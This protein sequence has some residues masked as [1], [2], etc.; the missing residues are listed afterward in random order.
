MADWG[1]GYVTE[2]GYSFGYYDE[3]LPSRLALACLGKGIAAPGLGEEPLRVLE[4]GSGQG[5]TANI[6]AAVNPEIDYTAVDFNPTH[7]SAASS[8]AHEAGTPN[9][10]FL[11]ASFSDIAA[12]DSLGQFDVITLHG[13]YTWVSAENREHIIRIA[14]DKL[15]TGGLLYISYNCFPGWTTVAPIRRLFTDV[16]AAAP[17][18]PIFDRLDQGLRLFDRLKEVKARYIVGTPGLVERIDKIKTLQKNYVAH[19]YLNDEWT[20]FYSSDVAA[21]MARAKLT[22]VGSARPLENLNQFNFTKDQLDL[23]NGIR[24]GSQRELIRDFILNSQ[25]RTDI[26]IKGPLKI[27]STAIRDKWLNFHFALK[28]PEIDVPRKVTTPLG[29]AQLAPQVYDPIL[30]KLDSGPLSMRELLEDPSI[31]ALAWD[32]LCTAIYLLIGQGHCQLA[33]SRDGDKERVARADALNLAIMRRASD[34]GQIGFLASPVLGAGVPADLI[35]QLFLL[36]NREGA[37]DHAEFIWN[38]LK[39]NGQR[40]MKNN[41]PLVG[42]AANLNEVRA[43]LSKISEAQIR[44]LNHLKV[45]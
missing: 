26:F 8:L 27:S 16:S 31:S 37:T 20:V 10:K 17:K 41:K 6:I 12:D 23:L 21:D 43:S 28:V 15:K 25:F 35:K 2:V 29:E 5:L 9:I 3:I 14:R 11:E 42:D 36:A 45:K 7:I 19:E 1:D 24:D 4:L 30:K 13:I 18:T 32:S 40:L 34:V 33:C 39:A 44:T 22:F 38:I